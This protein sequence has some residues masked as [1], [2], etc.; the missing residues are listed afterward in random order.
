MSAPGRRGGGDHRRHR[1]RTPSVVFAVHGL[2]LAVGGA[3]TAW[4]AVHGVADPAAAAAF[5]ALVVVGEAF[6]IPEP[7]GR[8]AAPVAFAGA[9]AYA[10][11][12]AEAVAVVVAVSAAAVVAG[13]LRGAP[14]DA[15]ARRVLTVAFAAATAQPLYGGSGGHPGYAVLLLASTILCDAVLAAVLGT[16]RTG[17]PFASVLRDELA[18]LP[19]VGSAVCAGG[20]VLAQA[21]QA[22]GLWALPVCGVPLLLTQTAFRRHAA[23]RATHRETIASLARATEVAGYTPVGHARRVS[24][25]S[26]AMGRELGL[27]GKALAALEHAALM[28]DIGQLSL[29]DP[30]PGGATSSLD[31]VERRRIALLGA[32]VVRRTGA[33]EEVAR[34]VEGQAD[35]YRDQPL[36]GRI[37][38]TANAYED[39]AGGGTAVGRGLQ[40]LERLRLD[41]AHEYDP[42]VVEALTRVV[43]RAGP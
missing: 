22:A 14:R 18:V 12:A 8:E 5:G 27:G 2:A 11:L 20:V 9:L 29:V 34:I 4:T 43:A 28:H 41:T 40:A 36:A 6:R 7:E 16:A 10:L 26:H 24:A 15:A 21:E 19:G 17:H 30:V 39:L 38:R 25:L 31:Q 33:P 13:Q 23:I 32:E 35:P 1:R 3:A 42:R 37:V